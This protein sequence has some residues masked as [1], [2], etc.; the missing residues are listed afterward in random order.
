MKKINVGLMEFLS[1]VHGQKHFPCSCGCD[2]IFGSVTSVGS[3]LAWMWKY[4]NCLCP[5]YRLHTI[6]LPNLPDWEVEPRWRA[7]A[8]YYSYL[9][10]PDWKAKS[11]EAKER[12]GNRCVVCAT[13]YNLNTHHNNSYRTL[14]HESPFDLTV[15]CGKHHEL[16]TK[17]GSLPKWIGFKKGREFLT[18]H[19][20]V[21]Q[22]LERAIDCY[23]AFLQT[24]LFLDKNERLDTVIDWI[25]AD[26]VEN[27]MDTIEQ[28]AGAK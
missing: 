25:I 24:L 15:L 27:W 9:E 4:Q 3:Q 11:K 23:I 20:T 5:P 8:E 22:N 13:T 7:E 17:Y 16:F 18:E 28:V 19:Y 2:H 14:G 12:A 10:H 26:D 6:L 21:E 1:T